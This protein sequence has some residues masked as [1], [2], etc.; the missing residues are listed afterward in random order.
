MH[1]TKYPHIYIVLKGVKITEDFIA[2]KSGYVWLDEVEQLGVNFVYDT[3]EECKKELDAYSEWLDNYPL[4]TINMNQKVR[5]TERTIKEIHSAKITF[6][7]NL[8]KGSNDKTTS[9]S[10]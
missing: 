1:S 2:N 8:N 10:K 9:K 5:L 3:I 4:N 7:N 6:I